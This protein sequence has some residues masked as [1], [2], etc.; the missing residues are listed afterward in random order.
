MIG[1]GHV[2]ATVA[3]RLAE[4]HLGEVLL[5]DG[6]DGLPQGTDPDLEEAGPLA[7]AV[8]CTTDPEAA[9][10]SDVV[11][12]AATAARRA[13][14]RRDDRRDA[15]GRAVADCVR[16]VVRGSRDTIL[17]V[18][19]APVSVM[20]EAARRASGFPRERV[21]GVGGIVAAAR[22][23]SLV[24][25]ELGVAAE[26]VSALVLGG[27]GQAMVPVPRYTTVCGVPVTELLPRERLDAVVRRAVEGGS[28]ARRSAARGPGN[29]QDAWA[30]A[31]GTWETVDAI[32]GDRK[33]ILP[34]SAYLAGEYGLDGVFVGVPCRLGG[35]G[36]EGV[37]EVPL[38]DEERRT[39]H[40]SAA[41]ARVQ[42]DALPADL[43]GR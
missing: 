41:A 20:C 6:G 24:A 18:V 36:M 40:A 35:A 26:S 5:V 32:V 43:A 10:D 33:K 2:G 14:M 12:V 8:S 7:G 28:A 11:V 22:L 39:L 1:G 31:A 9:A 27:D 23:R 34:C 13:G 4:G 19:T 42:A 21:L 29:G 25:R 38:S 30:A 15:D 3:L 17:V 37:F 16:R